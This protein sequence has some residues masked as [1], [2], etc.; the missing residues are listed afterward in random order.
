[1]RRLIIAAALLGSPSALIAATPSHTGW[2]FGISNGLPQVPAITYTV[3]GVKNAGI[4]DLHTGQHDT[5]LTVG[6]DFGRLRAEFEASYK[7][8]RIHVYFANIGVPVEIGVA[9]PGKY[10]DATGHI[11]VFSAMFNGTY[12][13]LSVGRFTSYGGAGLGLANI[14]Y[15]HFRIAGPKPWLNSSDTG[16]AWQ[17]L[18][19]TRFR[20]TRHL[21]LGV[22]VRYF[23][24]E[25]V[26]IRGEFVNDLYESHYRVRSYL[27]TLQYNFGR[28]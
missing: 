13:L 10:T 6:H 9:P 16:V 8:S 18:G 17:V 19:G 1:M 11:R 26:K 4:N 2:Y 15:D 25:T 22:K 28:S 7:A 24:I 14:R 20:M 3:D 27:G 12:D 23:N 21:D 5:D